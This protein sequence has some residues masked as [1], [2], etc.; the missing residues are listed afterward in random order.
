MISKLNRKRTSLR[1][2][3]IICSGTA[4]VCM[5]FLSCMPKAKSRARVSFMTLNIRYDNPAD[6]ENAW[7]QRRERVAATIRFHQAGIAGIQEALHHQVIDLSGMLPEYAWLG[8]GRENGREAGE[9]APVFYKK[10]RFRVLEKGHFWLSQTP[11]VPGSMGWDAACTRIVT[12]VR[13]YDRTLG[14][15]FYFINTHFDHIGTEARINSAKLLLKFINSK[16]GHQPVILCGDF[17]SLKTDTSYAVLTAGGHGLSEASSLCKEPLYGSTFTYNGFSPEIHQGRQ[18]DFI[19]V[20]NVS[21]V[22]R[23]GVVSDRWD[24]TFV[25]DHHAVIAEVE[26]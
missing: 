6:G 26:M 9:Y 24:G 3:W 10:D 13:F 8:V 18:I 23:Y 16:T 1:G 5:L 20:R 7:Q 12:W 21:A 17:N 15:S 14:T 4:A 2:A 25:S 19:F 11:E 22:T